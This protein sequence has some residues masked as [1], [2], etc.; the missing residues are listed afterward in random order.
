MSSSVLCSSRF[1]SRRNTGE[2]FAGLPQLC[3]IVVEVAPPLPWAPPA[4]DPIEVPPLP[5]APPLLPA[6]PPEGLVVPPLPPPPPLIPAPPLA[7]A[8]VPPSPLVWATALARHPAK[9]PS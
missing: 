9:A 8:I 6:T 1:V 7:C 5:P 3:P 4:P 2:P